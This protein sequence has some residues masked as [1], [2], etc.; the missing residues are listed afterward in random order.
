MLNDA[1]AADRAAFL[2]RE[3]RQSW[4]DRLAA[5]AADVRAARS[6][7]GNALLA[8]ARLRVVRVRAADGLSY[9]VIRGGAL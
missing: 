6:R 5:V 8:R 2:K 1:A 3:A 7:R 4:V 9:L